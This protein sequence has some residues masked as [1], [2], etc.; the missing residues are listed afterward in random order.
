[1]PED[2]LGGDSVLRLLLAGGTVPGIDQLRGLTFLIDG[3]AAVAIDEPG[4]SRLLLGAIENRRASR[5]GS[6]ARIPPKTEP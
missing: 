1:M 6:M 2:F 5:F 3:L 4:S